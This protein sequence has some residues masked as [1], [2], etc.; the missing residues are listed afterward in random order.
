MRVPREQEGKVGVVLFALGNDMFKLRAKPGDAGCQAFDDGCNLYPVRQPSR[1]APT[2]T[3]RPVGGIIISEGVGV[4]FVSVP[5]GALS[6]VM[7]GGGDGAAVTG[8]SEGDGVVTVNG[9]GDG[10]GRGGGGG[11]KAGAGVGP[12][13]ESPR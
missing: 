7:L 10:G 4:G 12:G 8:A 13:S 2:K 6:G 5:V 9:G 1:I 11:E 3:S